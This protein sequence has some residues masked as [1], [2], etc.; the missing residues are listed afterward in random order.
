MIYKI[1]KRIS[2]GLELGFY[3]ETLGKL[4]EQA[5][6]KLYW[7]IAE[8]F[9]PEK[10]G[11]K[12]RYQAK[13]VVEIGP[14]LSIET[15]FSSNAVAI[16]HSMGIPE[17]IRIER[18]H[19]YITGDSGNGR[20][21]AL[22]KMDKMT[23]QYYPNG[24]ESFDTGTMPEDV[25]VIDLMGRGKIAL[26][27]MNSARGLGMDDR[28]IEYYHHLFTE[29][30]KRN[31]KD[32]EL[33]QLGNANSEHSRH[34]YFKGRMVI[35][36]TPM[37][38]T[39]F[40]I[41]QQPL[42]NLGSKTRSLV[43]FKDNAGVVKGFDTRLI[44][45]VAPGK[46][47]EM[48]LLGKI[49]HITCTAETHNHP[50][51]V[52]PFNG[53]GT[54]AGGRIRDN[55]APGQGA[56]PGIGVAGYFV[57]NLF[58]PGYLIPGEVVG[59]NKLSTY[60]SP[61]QILIKGSDGVSA[62]G[63]QF[64]EPLILGFCRTF[65]QIVNGEW[66]EPRKPILYSG[67]VGHIF[68]EHLEKCTPEAGMKIVRIGGPA[69]PIGVGGG[70]ASSMMQGQ[71]TDALDFNSV[72]RGNAE[73]ENRANRVIRACVEMG[74]KSPISSIHDQGA[75]GPSNVL[76]ELLEPLGGT[77]NI[78]EIVLG[79]KTMSVL[80]IWSAEFQEGYGLLIRPEQIE[81]FQSICR[82]E[83]V[84]CEVLGEIN[85]SRKIVVEDPLNR[86]TP[87]DLNLEQ[88][89][90]NMPQKTFK[91]D[92]KP[93]K[94]KPLELP[95]VT[96]VQAIEAVFK[97]PSVGSKGYLVH[98]V[99][100]SV[101]GLVAQQQCC[102]IAQIPIA[103]Y[104]VNAQ[105]HF[106]FTGAVSALGEQ[107]IKMLIDEKAGARMAVG[108]MLT[109]M[110]PVKIS[111]INDIRCRANWMCPA[112]LPHEGAVLYDAAVAMSDLMIELGIAV[113]G[114]KDSLSMAATVRGELVKAPGSLVILGYAPV[115]DITKK[116]TPDI[117]MP[118]KS[119]L[120]L[121][122]LGFGKNRLG[123]SALA[124]AFNQLG[125]E[126]PDVDDPKLLKNAFLAVQK[127]IS[128]GL[129]LAMHDRSDGGLITAVAEMCMA[130][131]CGFRINISNTDTVLS[132]LFTE[133]LGFVIELRQENEGAIRSVC[134]QLGVPFLFIGFPRNDGICEIVPYTS[135][136]VFE[137]TISELR[138]WWE[139][140]SYE[141]EK[142]QM[143]SNCA[144]EEYRG[145]QAVLLGIDTTPSY[146]LSFT[147]MDTSIIGLI[148]QS[149]PRVA[150]IRE[151]GTN[152]DREMAAACAAAGLAPWDV[153]M[154]DLL[155]D[156][157]DLDQFRGVIFPG[158]FSY[159]DVF[160][161]AK[162]WAGTI[163]FN[164]KLRGMFDRFYAREDTFSLGVCNGCQ[165][166]ALL[167][168]VPWK[169]GVHGHLADIHQPR[170]IHNTSGRFESRWVQV[171]VLP[172]PSVLLSGMEGSK[173]GVWVAHGEGRLFFPDQ[174]HRKIVQN[175]N[176]A[177]L[178]YLDPHG[179]RTEVYP[180]NPN[181][182]PLGITALCS[183]D[184]R[185]LAM[186]PHP[187]RCF[188]LWQWPW[189][190]ASWQKFEASPWL[191]MFQNARNWCLEPRA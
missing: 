122:D 119:V 186:M 188:R 54:G 93:K 3:V 42:K 138:L 12:P 57:G 124:Q 7:L 44:L 128:Q 74:D 116:I 114:G 97:L 91:S 34:W 180:Y 78:R 187:E 61:L 130:S 81:F 183:P 126:S 99:D 59:S 156:R 22:Q 185:H 35:D 134:D 77:I 190:P 25:Q 47:S 173:L 121:I 101:T 75:G 164:E 56:I 60:A 154:S 182:S 68:D 142:L 87:V 131:R 8:T 118:G 26:E 161:S 6:N 30:L 67:G 63:N 36:G 160:D 98:K 145:N 150:V 23:E 27:E 123:G 32:V 49:I 139:S 171:E 135:G 152:G 105:S 83:R 95:K 48:R 113:D 10:T 51:G 76:T 165:L 55:T 103:D 38:K 177:P 168:W 137:S 9:E 89:L 92:R 178:A 80:K 79:D 166:M 33:F 43:A 104:S 170:F 108:E 162:G 86:Q 172:S 84:N 175:K 153:M 163:L 117:K 21:W 28:D 15:P 4:S 40:E 191:R 73:M 179:N 147:P 19:L 157:I 5:L 109:N 107:P 120:G 17:I 140:T 181:G 2:D 111:S 72:Q 189:M 18:T 29:V 31:P 174:W 65:G 136:V 39:L 151:E 24:I 127:M 53:A 1:Y 144:E 88:V 167:G 112:K 158:G 13:F 184:G 69:Y 71:N 115:P 133:E 132:E 62:Y 66:R 110:A 129:I 82:R 176:L 100:R 102:G 159:M 52:E 125:D 155:A 85:G 45:P 14:R 11:P 16:T 149:K 143:N 58:V 20:A 94:L 50:T 70:S 90:T 64:G 146:H 169:D 41:V 141:I 148:A 96:A 46:P 37:Q 106:G